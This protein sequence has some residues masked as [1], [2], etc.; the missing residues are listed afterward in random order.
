MVADRDV[1]VVGQERLVG[2]EELAYAGGVVDGGVEVG[3]VGDVDGLDERGSSDGVQGGFGSLSAGWGFVG[4]EERREGL[5]QECP[6]A[7]AEG[8]ER[9]EG[10]GLA[11][12]D[13]GRRKQAGLGA[14]VKV[15]EMSSDG[16][17]EM[18][19][20]LQLDGSVWQMSERE[21]SGGAIC[22]EEPA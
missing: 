2:T 11:G 13:E 20:A 17:A 12:F 9:V 14:G 15:E 4:V 1:F 21:V 7:V 6:G 5:A 18:L 8:H 10:G 22:F 3:V 19:L 16:D